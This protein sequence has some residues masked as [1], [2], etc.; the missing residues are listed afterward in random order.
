MLMI[1]FG[2]G[3]GLDWISILRDLINHKFK[4]DDDLI[5]IL[6]IFQIMTLLFVGR[7]N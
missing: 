2:V 5:E 7:E 4:N 6:Q 3:G 1:K